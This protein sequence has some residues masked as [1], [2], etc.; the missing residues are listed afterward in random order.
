[1]EEELGIDSVKLG[2]VFSVLREKTASEKLDIPREEL[3]SIAGCTKAAEPLPVSASS[4]A[5]A[6]AEQ[7]VRKPGAGASCAAV[8]AEQSR[9]GV[10]CRPHSG[11]Q[12]LRG[13]KS[14]W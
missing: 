7:V 8:A 4:G 13:K 9:G 6:A 2:E 10:V 5:A 3:K 11:A 12:A 1:L 14:R